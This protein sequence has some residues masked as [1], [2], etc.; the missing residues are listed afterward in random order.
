MRHGAGGGRLHLRRQ[1]IV[2]ARTS[3]DDG[4]ANERPSVAVGSETGDGATADEDEI[5]LL[6]F[7]RRA[8]DAIRCHQLSGGERPGAGRGVLSPSVV[9]RGVFEEGPAGILWVA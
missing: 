9:A 4:G 8:N 6:Q 1:G 2:V 3:G 5:E 7:A